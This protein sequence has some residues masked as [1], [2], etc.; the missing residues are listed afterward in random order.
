MSTAT[1]RGS[2]SWVSIVTR[3]RVAI[4]VDD[5][6]GDP[7]LDPLLAGDLE[8]GREDHLIAGAQAVGLAGQLDPV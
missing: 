5:G 6:A 4:G 7:V 3:S 8:L 1:S 2:R